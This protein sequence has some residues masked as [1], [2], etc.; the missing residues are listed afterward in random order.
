MNISY[1]NYICIIYKQLTGMQTMQICKLFFE[2]CFIYITEEFSLRLFP[3][4]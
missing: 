3:F 1:Y 2:M 4:Y